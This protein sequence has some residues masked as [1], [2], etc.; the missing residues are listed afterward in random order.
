M[1]ELLLGGIATASL[2]AG[3]I[4]LRYWLS[5]GDR[6]FLLFAASFWLEAV[7]RVHMGLTASWNEEDLPLHYLVRLVSYGLILVAIWIK[8]RPDRR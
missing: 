6:F 4:F 8:N 2:V 1:H 3:L 5:T 7:N